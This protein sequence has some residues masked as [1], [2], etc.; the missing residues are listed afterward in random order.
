[1]PD[2]VADDF[3]REAVALIPLAFKSYHVPLEELFVAPKHLQLLKSLE[4]PCSPHVAAILRQGGKDVAV[5]FLPLRQRHLQRPRNGIG[6]EFRVV[7]INQESIPTFG[8]GTGEPRENVLLDH[9]H[10]EQ[11]H[12]PS[13][14]GSCRLA[15][16]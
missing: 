2:R 1:M 14:L 13:P 12:I 3:W 5:P 16:V 15:A 8:G 6:Y 7:G 10:P 4:E 11:R 9:Q